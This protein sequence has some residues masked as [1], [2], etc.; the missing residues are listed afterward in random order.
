MCMSMTM[1]VLMRLRYIALTRILL[2]VKFKEGILRVTE[3]EVKSAFLAVN[4]K[5][6]EQLVLAPSR[7]V[8]A[9]VNSSGAHSEKLSEIR[10]HE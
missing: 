2:D 4:S 1:E 7:E 9:D 6:D 5:F 3:T 10:W 8:R